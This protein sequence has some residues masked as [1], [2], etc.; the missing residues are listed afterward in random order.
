M[1]EIT[2]DDAQD[3]SDLLNEL[4]EWVIA[5]TERADPGKMGFI[6]VTMG[7]EILHRH[8]FNPEDIQG[9]IESGIMLGKIWSEGR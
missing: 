8:A 9:L 1:D 7:S 4:H 2:P 3:A 5:R 6:L